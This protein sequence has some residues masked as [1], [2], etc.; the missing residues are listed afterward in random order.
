MAENQNVTHLIDSALFD[1]LDLSLLEKVKIQAQVLVPVL[2][3]FRAELGAA[4]ANEIADSALREWSLKVHR[5][6]GDQIPGSPRQKWEA[7]TGAWESRIGSDA[8]IEQL[9]QEPDAH[10]FNSCAD[11]RKSPER[12]RGRRTG[13]PSPGS[14]QSVAV[15]LPLLHDQIGRL[16]LQLVHLPITGARRRPIQCAAT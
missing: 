8:D 4:K 1:D 14:L 12:R 13:R 15:S 10:D 5:E 2:R 6:I 9:K 3:A 11:A 16:A 7:I